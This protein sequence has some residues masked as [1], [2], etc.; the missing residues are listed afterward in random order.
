MRK[1][2]TDNPPLYNRNFG[3]VC[4]AGFLLY[5]SAYAVLLPL[6]RSGVV[7]DIF[8]PFLTGMQMAG[9]FNAWLADKFRR[10]H[11]LGYPFLGMLLVF[12]GYAYASTPPQY[13]VLALLHGVC[14]GLATSAAVTLS[15]DVVHTGHRT[16]AN[17]VYAFC[18]RLGMVIGGVAGLWL[19]P[20]STYHWLLPVLA[21]GV[22][23]LAAAWMYVPFRAP[24]GLPMVSSDRYL[25]V[26][27][28]LPGLNVA[29]LAFACGMLAL[30]MRG[31]MAWLFLLAVLAPWLVRMFVKLSHHCQRATGNVTFHFFVDAGLLLGVAY[32]QVVETYPLWEPFAWMAFAL[33]LYVGVTRIYYK[34]M[35]VR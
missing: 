34:K 33:V 23:V 3:L 18:S 27:A 17:M 15:I 8:F 16:K 19:M 7:L 5:A 6:M 29:I 2:N 10:K 24:I 13:A 35:R 11:V 4:V 12:I 9:A 30:P 20:L 22:G 32:A 28:L 21:G 14:F 31:G 26:R 1:N 25:L